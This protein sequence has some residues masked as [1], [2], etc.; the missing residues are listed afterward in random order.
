MSGGG[1]VSCAL[2]HLAKGGK[3]MIGISFVGVFHGEVV[4]D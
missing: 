4:D 2:M 1:P 3:E